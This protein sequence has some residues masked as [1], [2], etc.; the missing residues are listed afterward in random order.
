MYIVI[1]NQ[2]CVEHS[3]VKVLNFVSVVIT[4]RKKKSPLCSTKFKNKKLL[5]VIKFFL[6]SDQLVLAAQENGKIVCLFDC[7]F[8]CYFI[9]N[10]S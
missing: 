4:R 5:M 8:V 1:I 3:V 2:T 7:L 9:L 10:N 6:I